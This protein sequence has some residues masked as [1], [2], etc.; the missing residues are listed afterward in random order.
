[1]GRLYIES[2]EQIDIVIEILRFLLKLDRSGAVEKFQSVIIHLQ[3]NCLAQVAL[4]PAGIPVILELSDDIML[5]LSTVMTTYFEQL[6]YPLLCCYT[7]L[8]NCVSNFEFNQFNFTANVAVSEWMADKQTDSVQEVIATLIRNE[9]SLLL[10]YIAKSDFDK[11]D[12]KTI[13]LMGGIFEWDLPHSV[14]LFTL[15]LL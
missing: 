14:L 3:L 11:C 12:F 2:T 10:N 6:H 7:C 9:T 15:E 4:T 1:M 5:L 8:L 13:E